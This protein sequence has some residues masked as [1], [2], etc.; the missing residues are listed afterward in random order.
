MSP[1]ENRSLFSRTPVLFLCALVSCALWGSAIPCIKLSYALFGIDTDNPGSLLLFAG[2]RF[3]LAGVL[4]LLAGSLMEH[5][6]LVPKKGDWPSICK[7]SL[8]QTVLQY[9]CYYLALRYTA[10]VTASILVGANT[11]FAIFIAAL[12]FRMERLTGPKLAGCA[13]GF[14]GVVLS[15]LGGAL[16]LSFSFRGEGLILLSTISA[17]VSS[18]LIR[19]YS[20]KVSPILLSG[21]QFFLGG[22][23]L[24]LAGLALGGSWGAVS[25]ASVGML[26]YLAL[27]SAVAYTLWGC[28]LKENPV[29]RVT[30][31]GFLT[32]VF[33]VLLSALLLRETG[34]LGGRTFLALALVCL[35]IWAVNRAP[36]RQAGR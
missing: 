10:G 21:W 19:R 7:V 17:A 12:V 6:P 15:Q 2:V 5:R 1:V 30:V 22:L 32:P 23:T 29:S 28:L 9:L 35:G 31:F 11:F 4:V 3:A 18:A 24:A 20:A 25:P 34:G 36:E 14:A 13:V 26:V 33:G 27:V 8:F 16:Q